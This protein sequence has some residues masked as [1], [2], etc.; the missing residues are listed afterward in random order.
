MSAAPSEPPV[1][2]P[3]I[4]QAPEPELQAAPDVEPQPEPELPPAPEPPTVPEL[5]EASLPDAVSPPPAAAQQAVEPEPAPQQEAAEAVTTDFDTLDQEIIGIFL[6]E[7]AEVLERSD[8]ALNQWRDDINELS[9]VQNLQREIHTFKGGARMAGLTSIGD[10]SH[11]METLL[12]R[13][14]EKLMTPSVS[15][16]AV[17][18]DACDRLQRWVD[19]VSQRAIPDATQALELLKQSIQ[20]LEDVTLATILRVSRGT[21]LAVENATTISP[22]P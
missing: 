6:E 20:N 15:A 21:R 1:S 19:Q 3:E 8:S 5:E 12:E 2:E 7:A 16:V 4:T 11:E 13:M 17:L 9:W 14:A 22:E 18:E 10:Y